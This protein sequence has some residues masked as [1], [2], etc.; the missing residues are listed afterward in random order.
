VPSYSHSKLETFE[1]C[2]LQY[3]FNYID[4]VEVERETTVEAFL[5]SCVHEAL[6]KLYRDVRFEK[7]PDVEE[8]LTYYKRHW[9]ENWSEGIVINREDYGPENYRKMGERYIRDYY[10]RHAPFQEGKIIGLE[11]QNF[12]KLDK[13]Q[14][15]SYHIRIDRL[16]DMGDGL[17]EV[18]DYKTNMSLPPQ[19]KLDEDRQLAMY[20]L[21][22]RER[23]KDFKRA[24]LVWHFVAFDREMESFRTD[25][26]L[27][28]QR[29]EVL[30]KIAEIE[31]EDIFPATV[32]NLC[33]WCLYKDICPEWK[34]EKKLEGKTENEFLGDPGVK[35][36][37]AYV[38][39]KRELDDF[40]REKQEELEKI[41]EALIDLSNKEDMT[42]I[43]GSTHK[44]SL[45]EKERLK[46]PG[47][48]TPE[49]KELF[50][51]LKQAGKLEEVLDLDTF[52]LVRIIDKGEWE[53]DILELLKPF[54]TREK[55]VGLSVSKK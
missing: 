25:E 41:K 17:Y 24:R 26:E 10:K 36:V 7:I 50:S 34:H 19:K 28:H 6:E 54:E 4:K 20:S 23:F 38:R 18:H 49:R 55:S 11:T 30:D 21:W 39:L 45:K 14:K 31:K 1:N 8:I 43:V 5:G 27:E 46:L 9:E 35:L 44:V 52:S 32:S 47:K 48:N 33:N 53:S 40:S 42:T 2:R 3:R 12:L 51:V 13:E 22:V 37:D 15:Y 16:M 29:R